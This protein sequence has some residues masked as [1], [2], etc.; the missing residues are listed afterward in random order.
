MKNIH[1][2]LKHICELREITPKQ[3]AA[4]LCI[5]EQAYRKIESG[6]TRLSEKHLKV[7]AEKLN[8]ST[9][10]IETFDVD[11]ILPPRI[12]KFNPNDAIEPFSNA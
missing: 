2:N 11:N 4:Y 3:V 1:K 10:F 5:S 8:V 9:E 7:L 6:A 12:R